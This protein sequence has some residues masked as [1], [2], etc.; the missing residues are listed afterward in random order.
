ML[1]HLPVIH[2]WQCL[3]FEV[4]RPG[5]SRENRMKVVLAEKNRLLPRWPLVPIANG[6]LPSA[7]IEG[8]ETDRW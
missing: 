4:N 1:Q 7:P 2:I 5:P 6:P 3:S 8:V